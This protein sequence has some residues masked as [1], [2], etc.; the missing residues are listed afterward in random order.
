MLGTSHN[1]QLP[2]GL[3]HN[4]T[5]AKWFSTQQSTGGACIIFCFSSIESVCP[6]WLFEFF[7]IISNIFLTLYSFSLQLKY[8]I[9]G[10]LFHF[11]CTCLSNV[12]CWINSKSPVYRSLIIFNLNSSHRW[13]FCRNSP[14][15]L[16][17]IN[18]QCIRM[19][20]ELKNV[21]AKCKN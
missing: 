15:S 21:F 18:N 7:K 5:I 14:S 9:Q 11:C 8:F 4:K 1:N 17:L 16:H 19:V 20:R 12:E 10:K 6:V 3:P 2:M 13:K